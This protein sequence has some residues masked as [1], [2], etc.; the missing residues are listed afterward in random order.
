[1]F[2]TT[3]A[4][5]GAFRIL[6]V[7]VEQQY[8]DLMMDGFLT[9]I[10]RMDSTIEAL[11]DRIAAGDGVP[12]EAQLMAMEQYESLR[13]Q[14]QREY[15][16]VIREGTLP[17]VEALASDA[18]DLGMTQAGAMMRDQ[19]GTMY[20][21]LSNDDASSLVQSIVR[22][23][24]EVRGITELPDTIRDEVR[25]TITSG[26]LTG[27]GPL[28]VKR[29]LAGIMEG[30][31]LRSIETLTRTTMMMA[32][33]EGAIA[34]YQRNDDL[35]AGWVWM[36]ALGSATPCLACLAMH[37]RIF[38]I[39]DA[40]VSHPNCR[41][42]AAPKSIDSM[43]DIQTGEEWLQAQP[44]DAQRR[45]L[46]PTLHELYK[47]G[48]FRLPE[49]VGYQ[50]TH[51]GLNMRVR[52]M[53][54]FKQRLDTLPP[55]LRQPG[56]PKYTAS[57]FLDEIT[58]GGKKSLG[59]AVKHAERR[60]ALREELN[61]VRA[62]IREM[63]EHRDNATGK[64]REDLDEQIRQLKAYRDQLR[65]E[66]EEVSSVQHVQRGT[67]TEFPQLLPE[68]SLYATQGGPPE[69][70]YS[71][72]DDQSDN[73]AIPEALLDAATREKVER[74]QE[75]FARMITDRFE[76]DLFG[77]I[78]V[79][80]VNGRAYNLRGVSHVYANSPWDVVLHELAHNLEEVAPELYHIARA[81]ITERGK[82]Y[83]NNILHLGPRYHPSEVYMQDDWKH[84]TKH[85]SNY[86][87][88][89]YPDDMR[90]TEVWTMGLQWMANDPVGLA[91]TFPELFDLIIK[92][93]MTDADD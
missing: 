50:E 17:A 35:L 56:V 86:I 92:Y 63:E 2:H 89:L 37:G 27:A 1:V 76:E 14:I 51:Y 43:V 68:R 39:R 48:A 13:R 42:T 77:E 82:P 61:G 65:T 74:G 8:V 93:V 46:G 67:I 45:I 44:E 58:D 6:G 5:A 88:K 75:T 53:A 62:S 79:H 4:L 84:D 52:P 29:Q 81:W 41:C 22:D 34:S 40:M 21:Q 47:R 72:Y 32:Q 18:V 64:Q 83:G 11:A 70:F 24:M 25:R 60:R 12:S 85:G 54:P 38:P 15:D 36:T 19:L 10:Q 59:S 31:T 9:A 71:T 66:Y 80:T 57:S 20:V 55:P 69:V 30:R 49:I 7:D 78:A 16:R 87:G 91:E 28:A 73:P 3:Q 26:L 23:R 33:R 90:A